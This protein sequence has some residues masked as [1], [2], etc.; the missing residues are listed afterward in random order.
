[1]TVVAHGSDVRLLERLPAPLTRRIVDSLLRPNVTIR[2]VSRELAA[3]LTRVCE[4]HGGSLERVHVAPCAIEVPDLPP[5]GALRHALRRT[6]EPLVVVVGR[7][8]KTKRLELS[9]LAIRR[10][11]GIEPVII[12]DGPERPLLAKQ[13]PRTTFLGSLP[14]ATTLRWIRAADLL[15]SA[16]ELEGAPTVV[17]EA[18][19]LDTPVVAVASGDLRDWAATDPDLVVVPTEAE[20]GSAE[21][22][23]DA[24]ARAIRGKMQDCRRDEPDG[25]ALM[26]FDPTAFAPLASSSAEVDARGDAPAIAE[27]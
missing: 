5:R 27:E 16:S 18:R 11:L 15:V 3:R 26:A 4:R 14:R 22:Q 2:C 10:A 12:G 13:F 6:G 24:L 19:A 23:L 20:L 9:I 21:R 1:V 8:V 25:S 17:R 7:A